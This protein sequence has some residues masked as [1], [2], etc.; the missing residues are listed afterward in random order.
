MN[1][2]DPDFASLAHDLSQLLWA[3]QGR[4]RVLAT[5][6]DADLAAD[7]GCLA[8]DA[9]MAAAMLADDGAGPCGPAGRGA[10]GLAPG[11]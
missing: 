3:I 7:L 2:D 11:L 1:H 9:A 6:V 4:A 10:P 8:E 5:R